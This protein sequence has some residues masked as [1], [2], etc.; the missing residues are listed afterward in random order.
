MAAH[1]ATYVV[2]TAAQAAQKVS[3]MLANDIF[4]FTAAQA[5]Q[6]IALFS[7]Y[8]IGPFTAAQAAQKNS[9]RA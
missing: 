4:L 2:F 3:L 7:R 1:P 8:A 5:A 9:E 6:K